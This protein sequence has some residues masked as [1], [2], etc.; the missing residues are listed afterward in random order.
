MHEQWL[1][2]PTD[3]SAEF[4]PDMVRYGGR[5]LRH[6]DSFTDT[7]APSLRAF[8]VVAKLKQRM[9]PTAEQA[10]RSATRI[11]EVNERPWE[12]LWG[13]AS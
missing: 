4:G 6:S 3:T 1:G 11:D 7:D 5:R 12:E 10:C 8:L 2:R 13:L 9:P